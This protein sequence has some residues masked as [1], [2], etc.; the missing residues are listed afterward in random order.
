M[1][2]ACLFAGVMFCI[3]CMH[4][5]KFCSFYSKFYALY[6]IVARKSKTIDIEIQCRIHIHLRQ[7]V[8]SQL[9]QLYPGPNQVIFKPQTK[10][11]I[12]PREK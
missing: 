4:I 10:C 11:L 9:S 12:V 2:Y 1:R 5:Y 3:A 6:L 7:L 8:H